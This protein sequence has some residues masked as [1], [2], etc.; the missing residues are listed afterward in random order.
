MS[1]GKRIGC[2]ALCLAMAAMSAPATLAASADIQEEIDGLKK[3][4][5]DLK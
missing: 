1:I 2:L 3:L 5:E 4:V